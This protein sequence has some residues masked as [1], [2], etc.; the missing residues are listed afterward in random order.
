M[1]AIDS[2]QLRIV[3]VVG[4]GT[5]NR[6]LELDSLVDTIGE[7]IA[8]Y[9]PAVG[10]GMYIRFSESAPLVII[11]RTGKYLITGAESR[12][13]AYD[14][15]NRLVDLLADISVLADTDEEQF[16]IQNYVCVGEISESLNLNALAIGLG[17]ER[18]E[19]EPEQFP[20][21]IYRPDTAGVALLFG[22]GRIVI[23]G[24]T[25]TDGAEDTFSN[26][27]ETIAELI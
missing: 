11:H 16:A 3:N 2:G 22:T 17:L 19:Y 24:C 25:T 12:S 10:P 9:E 6:E 18:T 14:T 15:R 5:V 7:P 13:M 27:V 20:G 23:T 21:L 8:Q 1:K 4:S 26:I